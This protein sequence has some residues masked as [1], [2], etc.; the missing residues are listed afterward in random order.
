MR[1]YG[2]CVASSAIDAGTRPRFALVP[3]MGVAAPQTTKP[4]GSIENS[5]Q[6]GKISF[7]LLVGSASADDLMAFTT[8]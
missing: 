2:R 6:N 1:Y 8:F 5:K 7:G 3:K 4:S